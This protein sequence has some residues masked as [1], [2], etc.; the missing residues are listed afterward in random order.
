MCCTADLPYPS[1]LS[2]MAM[3]KGLAIRSACSS[4]ISSNASES[5]TSFFSSIPTVAQPPCFSKSTIGSFLASL[6]DSSISNSEYLFRS[7][8]SFNSTLLP[9]SIP[10]IV[11]VYLPKPSERLPLSFCFNSA[12]ALLLLI[13]D[14]S[15]SGLFFFI[16]LDSFKS[17]SFLSFSQA[18]LYLLDSFSRPSTL[19]S[20]ILFRAICSY[21]G[22]LSL[23]AFSLD[24]FS[25][26]L[27]ASLILCSSLLMC[28]N[29]ASLTDSLNNL[30]PVL[31]SID[32][33][34]FGY[35]FCNSLNAAGT[36][37][38][39]FTNSCLIAIPLLITTI[40]TG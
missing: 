39:V 1:C 7:F 9:P 38:G 10:Y 6:T 12:P 31:S 19:D 22:V 33:L 23:L 27:I 18:A 16:V 35:C 3:F 17:Y 13:V 37:S 8:K 29:S 25:T 20:I 15:L 36:A 26:S 34:A 24:F 4:P 30:L 21:S 2:S 28:L 40:V 5:F 14:T 11:A 32:R